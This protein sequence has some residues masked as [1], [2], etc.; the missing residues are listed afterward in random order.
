[1]Q[2]GVD[3][4]CRAVLDVEGRR[5]RIVSVVQMAGARDDARGLA[6]QRRQ[7]RDR[8]IQ[9]P[10]LPAT[11]TLYAVCP[12]E[13]PVPAPERA[14]AQDDGAH[15]QVVP[16]VVQ[17]E[18]SVLVHLDHEVV[19]AR[20]AREHVAAA[21]LEHA[22]VDD[23]ARTVNAAPSLANRIIRLP[24]TRAR[25]RDDGLRAREGVCHEHPPHACRHVDDA[26][27]L[28]DDRT[29]RARLRDVCRVA[30][31]AAIH[32]RL[33]PS[34]ATLGGNG[35]KTLLHDQVPIRLRTSRRQRER[36]RARLHDV[37][38]LS[39]AAPVHHRRDD[40]VR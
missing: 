4:Q 33:A 22:L 17:L 14:A 10:P 8:P 26:A 11:A 34:E 25:L 28:V 9:S 13:L 21:C 6:V 5:L 30:D 3:L 27:S 1:M 37:R 19:A 2:G 31:A 38:V 24:R 29:A 40:L 32:R 15:R 7:H 20:V 36:A 23:P 18:L 35:H 39:R 12:H 16:G